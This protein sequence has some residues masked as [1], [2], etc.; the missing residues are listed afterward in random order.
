MKCNVEDGDDGIPVVTVTGEDIP[1]PATV[2][3]VTG[4]D[5]F[6]PATVV[7]VTGEDIPEPATVVTVTGEDIPEPATVVTV[8][9]EDI[10][11]PVKRMFDLP[12]VKAE[13]DNEG[14]LAPR[15]NSQARGTISWQQLRW[16]SFLLF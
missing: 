12:D 8:T 5:I 4:E 3:T 2:V 16:K 7:T 15:D 6:E 10:P 9:G 14:T 1:E 13:E 11:E